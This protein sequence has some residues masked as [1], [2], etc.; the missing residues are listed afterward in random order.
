MDNEKYGIEL[1][2]IVNKFKEKMQQV[3]NA[4]KGIDNKQVNITANTS[5]IN[6]LKSQINDLTEKIKRID[7]GFET[8]DVLKYEAQLEKVT[9]QYNKLISQQDTLKRKS[10]SSMSS[11]NKGFDKVMPK[12]RRFGFSLLG[13]RTIWS[14][15]SRASS[16]YVSQ[17]TELANKLQAVWLGLGSLLA[18]VIEKIADILIK[19]V[20]YINIFVKALTGVDLLAKATA[21]SMNNTAKSAK[22]LNKALAGF[23]ELTNLDTESAGAGGIDTSWADAFKD[24]EINTEWADRIKSFGEWVKTNWKNIVGSI[25]VGIGLIIG[26]VPGIIAVAIATTIALLVS[27]WDKIRDFFQEK[28]DWLASKADWVKDNFGIVGEIIYKNFT[29]TL[30]RI[31]NWFD[32]LFT[33]IRNIFDGIIKII[34]GVFTG[35]WKLAWEGVKQIFLN[36]WN[37]IK[38][39]FLGFVDWVWSRT[40]QP[41]INLFERLRNKIVEIFTNIGT[42]VG[43]VV[44]SAFKTV[45]NGVLRAIENILNSPIRAINGLIDTINKVPGINLGKLSTFNL[46]RLATGTNYVPEDQVAMIHKGEAV[47]PK[48]FNSREYFG[49]GNEEIN[50]KLDDLIEAV[51]NIEINPYTTI[52]DV[53]KASL[54]YINNKSRQLGESVVV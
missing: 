38:E 46:P 33:T 35:N 6:Y 37:F 16:A 42:K 41:V 21:K 13:I 34:T 27:N 15:V 23:D 8:G 43:E 54:S 53:G 7:K 26:G 29:D 40:I 20:T 32:L 36:I 24:V 45:I 11:M 22:S 28:I 25:I 3:K 4:F 12:I 17:D 14:L 10:N 39:T 49:T 9:N 47:V 52:K 50:E 18:P 51:R 1:E 19:G 2:L 30:Q 5:Q 48:K 44:G 31:L